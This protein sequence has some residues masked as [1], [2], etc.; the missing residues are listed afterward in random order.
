M[1]LS[2][3]WPATRAS[4]Q[5]SSDR[6]SKVSRCK[7]L[8]KHRIEAVGEVTFALSWANICSCRDDGKVASSG[9]QQATTFVAMHAHH[10]NVHD[11]ELERALD[12]DRS[13]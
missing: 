4:L 2:C 13:G 12:V 11:D 5:C 6:R 3:R 10:E 8:R 7:R 9:S 1:L